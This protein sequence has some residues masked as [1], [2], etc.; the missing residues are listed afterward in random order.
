MLRKLIEILKEGNALSA[1][2]IALSMGVNKEMVSLL[3]EELE[4][5]GLIQSSES[6]SSL[7]DKCHLNSACK[8]K[9]EKIY[10][11]KNRG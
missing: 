9:E 10:F 5:R 6:H 3:L 7:S 2:E 8:K 4:K 11:L 1:R